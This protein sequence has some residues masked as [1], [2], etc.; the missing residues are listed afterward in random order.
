M[1]QVINNP[2]SFVDVN[3]SGRSWQG[4]CA[5]EGTCAKNPAGP[6]LAVALENFVLV[7]FQTLLHPLHR[8]SAKRP[9]LRR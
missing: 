9:P 8:L 2:R 7:P 5:E 1:L 4:S 6:S 3:F